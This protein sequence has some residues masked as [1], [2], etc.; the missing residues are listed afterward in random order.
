[1]LAQPLQPAAGGQ[2][3]AAVT[4]AGPAVLAVA[5]E[6][7]DPLLVRGEDRQHSPRQQHRQMEEAPEGRVG[8]E[9]VARKQVPV[10]LLGHRQ[11][12]SPPRRDDQLPNQSGE[13]TNRHSRWPT[14]KPQPGLCA[15]G[16]P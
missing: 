10:N 12:V 6:A 16:W 15:A 2:A 1:M 5:L 3:L 9:Q 4:A 7:D 13:S 8:D 11:I 14:G